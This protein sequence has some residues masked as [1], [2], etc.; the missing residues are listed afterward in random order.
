[1]IP[2]IWGSYNKYIYRDRKHNRGY[3][4]LGGWGQGDFSMG[5]EFVGD[6]EKFW[7]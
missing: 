4:G 2:L 6:N 1:M 7:I 3:K 5:T